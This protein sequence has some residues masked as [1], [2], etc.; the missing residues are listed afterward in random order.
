MLSVSSFGRLTTGISAL[1]N[2]EPRWL[3]SS[4]QHEGTARRQSVKSRLTSDTKFAAFLTVAF[5][6]APQ[7][8][9]TVR[10]TVYKPPSL[11]DIATPKGLSVF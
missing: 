11:L 6:T 3:L 9:W 8:S 4:P 7:T 10:K 1:L 2:K 5:L